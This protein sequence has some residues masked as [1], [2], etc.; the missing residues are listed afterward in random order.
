MVNAFTNYN[1]S[2]QILDISNSLKYLLK[3]FNQIFNAK[4]L[5]NKSFISE[6][7]FNL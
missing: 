4:Y 3:K 2:K 6:N 5:Q 7:D 1:I